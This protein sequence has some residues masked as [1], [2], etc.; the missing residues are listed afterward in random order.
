MV[1]T[2]LG[3][4]ITFQPP[5]L[6][7]GAPVV[8]VEETVYAYTPANNG[9]GPMWCSGSTC[10]I[11][12]GDVVM[13]TGL[14][15]LTNTPP[16]NNCRWTLWRH[17]P[18]GWSRVAADTDGRT[19][20]P[21]PLA[22]LPIERTILVSANP[23]LRPPGQEGGGPA[24]P[25]LLAFS[26]E[27][28]TESPRRVPLSWRGTPEFTEHSYRSL[29]AD[30]A[31]GTFVLFQNIGYT[32]AE[33]THGT[34]RPQPA[35]LARGRL[36]WPWGA[37]Y[38][39]PQPV[40][41]CYPNVALRGSAVHFVG[42]SDIIEP[43]PAW[44]AFKKE[45]TGKEWDYEFRR[46]FYTWCPDLKTGRF[47][48][49][50]EIASREAT[51]GWITPGDLWLAPDGSVHILWT[52]RALDERLQAKFYPNARQRHAL[53]LAIVRDGKVARRVTLASTDDSAEI[54][55]LARFHL[56]P[57]GRRFVVCFVSGT[58]RQGRR[59]RENR[60]IELGPD[61]SPIQTV[62]IPLKHPF[63]S[64]FTATPRAGS[65]PSPFLDLLGTPVDTPNTIGYARIRLE[66]AEDPGTPRPASP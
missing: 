23:T 44:R 32:H 59:V 60:L 11:R 36:E 47:A 29:A 26:L 9:A 49:W 51:C 5:A 39:K 46:L 34:L 28:P 62:R 22:V 66:T 61:G 25:V 63:T 43:N 56:T 58:D 20:E 13:A 64:F 3:L 27:T 2:F 1:A 35:S 37:D 65:M 16:L 54:P 19:R 6:T 4:G 48:D 10:L 55:H 12:S 18:K 41:I 52:D 50:I 42:V 14:E 53:N 15:T 38:A 57:T 17:D 24:Q 31:A 45:L 21:S 40:R 7:A 33:W 8:E 30:A